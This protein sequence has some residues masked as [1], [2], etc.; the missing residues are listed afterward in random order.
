[1]LVVR[2][3]LGDL[4][5]LDE[6]LDCLVQA[7]AIELGALLEPLDSQVVGVP[8]VLVWQQTPAGQ[9][10]VNA[11]FWSPISLLIWLPRSGSPE[12]FE[13]GDIAAAVLS[14]QLL[15]PRRRGVTIGECR[16]QVLAL[17]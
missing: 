10:H 2:L 16:K 8:V 17:L 11:P 9:A 12:D 6:D 7:Q 15:R 1:M 14:P 13:A 4:H 5:R 3:V